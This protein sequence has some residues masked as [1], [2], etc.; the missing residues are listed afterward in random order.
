V[1]GQPQVRRVDDE[2]VA[3]RLDRGRLG[4]LGEQRRQLGELVVPVVQ[5][6][7]QV[8][9]AAARRQRQRPHRLEAAAR[10]DPGRGQARLHPHP[11]LG[12]GRP[13]RVGVEL[14]LER[15]LQADV[16]VV[17][18]VRGEQPLRPVLEQRDLLRRVDAER[19]D[20]VVRH[21]RDVAVHRLVGQLD[22][23]GVQRPGRPRHLDRR[24]SQPHRLVD[25]DVGAAR[26]APR[27]VV[28]DAD[29]EPDLHV[30]V[31]PL[32]A[33]VAQAE[34]LAT[35]PLDADVRRARPRVDSSLQGR[36]RALPQR[37][38]QQFR[39]DRLRHPPTLGRPISA[40]S[41]GVAVGLRPR[42]GR[43]RRLVR[44]RAAGCG[45]QRAGR[46]GADRHICEAAGPGRRMW[47]SA[48]GP[49][50]G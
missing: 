16:D 38:G 15:L 19:V 8:L 21:P 18:V 10:I 24:P 14:A 45:D 32:E 40:A 11:L 31:E 7:G 47:R 39:I 22:R 20:L 46:R 41:S 34:V 42:S 25:R 6:A 9:P 35:Q 26:E 1:D 4:L 3:P 37:Q 29:R 5:A 17:D 27:A 44:R 2:V 50:R 49:P 28:D 36:R 12:R 48:G 30:V 43:G 33:A 13:S 23:L